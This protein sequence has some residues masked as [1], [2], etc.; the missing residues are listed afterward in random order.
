M[1]LTCTKRSASLTNTMCNYTL[2][3]NNWHQHLILGNEIAITAAL[4]ETC[5]QDMGY[6][7]S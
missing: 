7:R 5:Y 3:T 1:Q 4:C 2:D 6:L